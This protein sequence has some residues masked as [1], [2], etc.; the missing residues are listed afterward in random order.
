ML[1]LQQSGIEPLPLIFF[2]IW[3]WLILPQQLFSV[4][5][6]ISLQLFGNV[7]S[8]QDLKILCFKSWNS[9]CGCIN[10]QGKG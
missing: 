9:L 5:I 10:F 6:T 1:S 7:A 3:D 2:A 4:W 8:C